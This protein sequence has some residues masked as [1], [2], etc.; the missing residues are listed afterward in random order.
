MKGI[1][2]KE[3][4]KDGMPPGTVIKMSLPPYCIMKG[5]YCKE[6]WKDGM[7][8]G[9]V[10]K[11]SKKSAYANTDIFFDWLKYHFVPRKPRDNAVLLILDG[12]TS[13]CNSVEMLEYAEDQ[14][15][16]LLCLP[17][18]T[19]HFLQPLDRCFFKSLKSYYYNECKN[20]MMNNP[21][22]RNV[23]VILNGTNNITELKSKQLA[24]KRTIGKK[25]KTEVTKT[26]Q[27]PKTKGKQQLSKSKKIIVESS[28]DS[29]AEVKSVHDDSDDED[30]S[31]LDNIC[32]GCG[33]DYGEDYGQTVKSDD[34]IQCIRCERW[35]H[36][37]CTK[38]AN[39]CDLCGK[40]ACKI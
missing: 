13:H 15:I 32:V 9:T 34:W 35:L 26:K 18:H 5:I 23:A 17:S 24:K 20:F 28:S 21:T 8:P 37:T 38:Y 40:C 27:K 4:W 14:N 7:P 12:H 29:D 16:I 30:Q 3:E 31:N 11:M 2:C 10:I 39:F 6:E 1:Y 36:E 19:T 25:T 22:N 33:E